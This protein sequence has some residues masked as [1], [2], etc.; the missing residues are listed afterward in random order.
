MRYGVGYAIVTMI[1]LTCTLPSLCQTC[2]AALWQHV[3]RRSRL[4]VV[5][6]CISVTGTVL[7]ITPETDGDLHVRVKLD[8]VYTHLLN[9]FN[10][11]RQGGALIVEPICDHRPSRSDARAAC[12]AFHQH[13]SAVKV[14]NHVKITGAYVVDTAPT[15]GWREIHPITSV[16][17]P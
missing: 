16:T 1:L 6:N 3:Y 12:G 2:D 4:K 5:S 10:N 13:F 15:N 17:P 9:G 7:S 11:K 14:G 8:P